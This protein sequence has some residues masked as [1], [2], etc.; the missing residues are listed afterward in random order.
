MEH[1][2]ISNASGKPYQPSRT[3]GDAK[4]CGSG[5]TMCPG[6][7]GQIRQHDKNELLRPFAVLI[8]QQVGVDLTAKFIPEYCSA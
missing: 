5:K 3:A 8:L 6:R 4:R 2:N 1:K 7:G